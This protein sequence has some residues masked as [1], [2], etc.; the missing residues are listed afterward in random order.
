MPHRNFVYCPNGDVIGEI[1]YM[2]F[3]EQKISALYVYEQSVVAG[4]AIP[5]RLPRKRGIVL[6]DAYEIEC[7]VC[8]HERDWTISNKTAVTMMISLLNSLYE[9]AKR[10]DA[11]TNNQVAGDV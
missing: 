10:K 6:G 1:V 9:P 3:G 7:T 8:R 2:E 4:A 11:V 5:D